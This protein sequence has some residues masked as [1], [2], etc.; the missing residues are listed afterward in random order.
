MVAK[1][2]GIS[3]NTGGACVSLIPLEKC[4]HPTC[5]LNCGSSQELQQWSKPL[6]A[7]LCTAEQGKDSVISAWL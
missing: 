5:Y 3:R 2:S 7:A 6:C 1:E 4:V